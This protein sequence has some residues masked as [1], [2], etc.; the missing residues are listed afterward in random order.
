MNPICYWNQPNLRI[1]EEQ[2]IKHIALYETLKKVARVVLVLLALGALIG[3]SYLHPYYRLI[4]STLLIVA[5]YPSI[6][7]TV[8]TLERWISEVREEQSR[9]Q[10]IITEL[11]P[12][13]S[14]FDAQVNALK[15]LPLIPMDEKAR[16]CAESPL[17]ETL[18]FELLGLKRERA[19]INLLNMRR[20]V[21]IA[22]IRYIERNQADT[23]S[24]ADFGSFKT[25]PVDCLLNDELFAVFTT[26]TGRV[27]T[28]QDDF[29]GIFPR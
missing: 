17:S 12:E 15:D 28:N 7:V 9:Y 20:H 29:T 13:I 21:E 6:Q 2:C 4:T 24:L 25:W 26:T 14:V 16:E 27:F 18:R 1:K 5:Y 23:R 10:A 11:R 19:R 22:Y 8:G 3:S